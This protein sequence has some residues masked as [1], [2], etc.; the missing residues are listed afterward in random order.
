MIIEFR[1]SGLKRLYELDGESKIPPEFV[2]KARRIIDRLDAAT[3]P[4]DM[5]LPGWGL[6][7]LKGNLKNHR[8]VKVSGNWR[9]TFRFDSGHARDVNL[10]DYH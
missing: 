7:K 2:K 1:H 9:I 3:H 8:A 4:S 10:I 6:H 5:D